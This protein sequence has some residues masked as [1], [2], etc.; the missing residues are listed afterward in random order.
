MSGS[1]EKEDRN[2]IV[3]PVLAEHLTVDT[4]SVPTGG[5]RIIKRVIEEQVAIEEQLRSQHAEVETVPVGQYV[6][7][8]LPVR[9]SDDGL[10]V[11]I[12]EEQVVI[13]RRW[14]LKE[15]IHIRRTEQVTPYRETVTVKREEATVERLQGEAPR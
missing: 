11:T 12:V 3:V 1:R 14:Y 6:D 15:E 7:G 8:P 5:V 13:E 10:V 4:V 2:E 9:Q